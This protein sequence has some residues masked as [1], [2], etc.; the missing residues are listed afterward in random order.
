MG[1]DK[2]PGYL[3]EECGVL[4]LDIDTRIAQLVRSKKRKTACY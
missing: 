1:F 4:E 3:H 2:V